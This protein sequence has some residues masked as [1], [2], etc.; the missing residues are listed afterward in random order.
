MVDI[1]SVKDVEKKIKRLGEGDKKLST[2]LFSLLHFYR[3]ASEENDDRSKDEILRVADMCLR[4]IDLSEFL[5]KYPNMKE[6]VQNVKQEIN[7]MRTRERVIVETVRINEPPKKQLSGDS[8]DCLLSQLANSI[9]RSVFTKSASYS[10][11][12]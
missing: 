3:R 7:E 4:K 5:E 12:S 11:V 2:Q 1:K 6:E 9:S 10:L 8:E